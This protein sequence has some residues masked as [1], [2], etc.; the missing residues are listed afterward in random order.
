MNRRQF[1]KLSAVGASAL[2]INVNTALA[3]SVKCP[4][5]MYHYV[6]PLPDDANR[7][8]RDLAVHPD[9]FTE[10]CTWLAENGYTTISMTQLY[11]HL[12]N[13]AALPENPVV[14]TFDDGYADAFGY[15]MPILRQFGMTGTFFIVPSYMEQPGY[16]TWGQAGEIL[17]AGMSVENHSL[18][19]VGLSRRTPEFLANEIGGAAD[20]IES[21]L[22][23][24]PRFFCYPLGRYDNTA[25]QAVQD[26]GHLLAVTTQDGTIM[27]SSNPYRLRRV[28][29]RGRT[30]TYS[31]R[32]LVNRW[33]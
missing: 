9:L 12:F 20:I 18:T 21:T 29:V 17:N 23:Y 15:A 19:H 1:L 4:I 7:Y 10:H 8:L 25:V 2:A 14:M 24:R 6:A 31:L 27:Y 3:S 28:R 16:L 5:L 13:G 33:V 26:S 11:D 32:W 22:G 30:N